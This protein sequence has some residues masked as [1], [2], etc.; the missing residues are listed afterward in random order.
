MLYLAVLTRTLPIKWDKL[1]PRASKRFG[2]EKCIPISDRPC[3]DRE[4]R[5][6]FARIVP[7]GRR[8]G[9]DVNSKYRPNL[10][11][12]YAENTKSVFPTV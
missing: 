9:L 10:N 1:E 2:E 11:A 3:F 4:V 12:N 7:K 6:K 8:F 5:L